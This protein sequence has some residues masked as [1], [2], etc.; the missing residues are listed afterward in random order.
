LPWTTITSSIRQEGGDAIL[1]N[2]IKEEFWPK[3]FLLTTKRAN[4]RMWKPSLRQAIHCSTSVLDSQSNEEFALERSSRFP[5]PFSWG[6][7][8]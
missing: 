6:K 1:G 2:P 4:T 5:N 7:L 8:L 3:F